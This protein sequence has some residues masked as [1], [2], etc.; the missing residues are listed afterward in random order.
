MVGCLSDCLTYL[1]FAVIVYKLL[2]NVLAKVM[3]GA[4]IEDFK[5][6]WIV[7][8]GAT[9]GIGYEFARQLVS[10]GFKVI[11]VSRDEK[12]LESVKKELSQV[13]DENNIVI[14]PADFKFSHRDP[15]GFYTSLFEK[16]NSYEVSG[17]INNVGVMPELKHFPQNNAFDNETTIGVNIYPVTFLTHLFLPK[18]LERFARTKQ[19]SLIL[20]LSSVAGQKPA[21]GFNVYGSTKRY[22]D[23][24]STA[25][26][27]EYDAAIQIVTA[28]PNV[29]ETGM[30]AAYNLDR[31]IATNPISPQEFVSSVFENLHKRCMAG[32]V[33]HEIPKMLVELVPDWLFFRLASIIIPW[34]YP[35]FRNLELPTAK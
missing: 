33:K 19:R 29:V 3:R 21:P 13:G 27:Y 34:S 30:P 5:Y 35:S 6:G 23:F 2:A 12:K 28:G 25:I 15:E 4:K 24:F 20:N 17:L 10:K 8:T 11:L 7:I 18:M 9:A 1:G 14:I 31:S 26:S 32:H 16:L 22:V